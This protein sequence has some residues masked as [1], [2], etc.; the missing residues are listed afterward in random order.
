[1]G[2]PPITGTPVLSSTASVFCT[3]GFDPS[4]GFEQG[5]QFKMEVVSLIRVILRLSLTKYHNLTLLKPAFWQGRH[6]SIAFIALKQD[7]Q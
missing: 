3:V 1:M 7:L 2:V 4:C 5:M 6:H